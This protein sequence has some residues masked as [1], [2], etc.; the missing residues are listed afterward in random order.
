MFGYKLECDNTEGTKISD[1]REALDYSPPED[2]K[3]SELMSAL[4][5]YPTTLLCL[6]ILV[7][8]CSGNGTVI[9]TPAVFLAVSGC[10]VKLLTLT[11][12]S[13]NEID[14]LVSRQ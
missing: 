9:A 12:S 5:S 11:M 14:D 2:S 3:W 7:P 4:S 6:I 1:L 10:F 13:A 8:I